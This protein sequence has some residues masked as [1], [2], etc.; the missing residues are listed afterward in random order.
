MYSVAARFIEYLQQSHDVD[1]RTFD[2]PELLAAYNA[3]EGAVD[4]Y[5][6]IPPYTETKR[7]V[8]KVLWLYLVGSTPPAPRTQRP[9]SSH[10]RPEM[11]RHDNV[12]TSDDVSL[13]AKFATRPT[14]P[15]KQGAL[16][17]RL[18]ASRFSPHST[19]RH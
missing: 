5:G 15:G 14:S 10:R 17:L 16:S 7:Y 4:R 12:T 18:L 1:G 13:L 19:T 11:T 6:G 2:L 3:G 9:E 8:A